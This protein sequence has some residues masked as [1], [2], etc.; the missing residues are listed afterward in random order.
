MRRI[1]WPSI[2]FSYFLSLRIRGALLGEQEEQLLHEWRRNIEPF[3][4]WLSK[5]EDDG[6]YELNENVGVNTIKDYSVRCKAS[7]PYSLTVRACYKCV[8]DI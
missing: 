5:V 3:N 8:K 1:I 2:L 4:N 7:L 6:A